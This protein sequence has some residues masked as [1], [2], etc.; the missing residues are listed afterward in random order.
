MRL[1][2]TIFG[3]KVPALAMPAMPAPVPAKSVPTSAGPVAMVGNLVMLLF[4]G[5]LGGW[6]ALAPLS[7]AVLAPGVIRVQGNNKT[8]QHLDG[9]I[10]SDILVKEGDYVDA[11]QVLIRVQD[12]QARATVQMLRNQYYSLLALSARLTAERDNSPTLNFSKELTDRKDDIDIAAIISSQQNLFEG[13]KKTIEGQTA[14]LRQ[15]VAQLREQMSGAAAQQ[16]SQDE[17]LVLIREQLKGTEFLFE[18][19]YAPKT[20]VLALQRQ[21]SAL[22]GQKAEYGATI[23]RLQQNIGETDLQILQL[24]KERLT[25]V[26]SQLTETQDKLVSGFERLRS[27]EDI[28]Q[29]TE[30]RAP[31]SGYVLGLNIH[32]VGGVLDRGARL[33]D[34]VPQD[35][36]KVVEAT[37]R[38]E[39]VK[40]VHEG[41]TA[42]VRLSAYKQREVPPIHGIV[43]QVSADRVVNPNDPRG[44]YTI[45]LVLDDEWKALP[46]VE[47]VPG[48]P[49][50]VTVPTKERTALQ[51]IVGP[52]VDYFSGAMRER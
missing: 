11:G 13:R 4:F 18:Q 49:V 25:E 30:I 28:L 34:I 19:G 6:A 47:L 37:L 38:P 33:L 27:G 45:S 29:R 1:P 20:Q 42:E 44:H 24:Q 3:G 17:Q 9:G 52:L 43:T 5:L 16:R 12:L 41:M 31:A 51:Y 2:V 32:T 14:V 48:M 15:R 21:A 40:D 26:S 46:G 35:T 36:L 10:V 39:D 7:S 50:T 22:V 23:A 8:V